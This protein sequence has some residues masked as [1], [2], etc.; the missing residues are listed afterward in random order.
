METYLQFNL[1][2][3]SGKNTKIRKKVENF[4]VTP[5]KDD[6]IPLYKGMT[7]KVMYRLLNP[8]SDQL[9][10]ICGSKK[11]RRDGAEHLDDLR[12][13]GWEIL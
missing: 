13:N 7:L 6:S 2:L 12:G 9:L 5:Q 11:A 8:G 10:V 1:K 3:Q 4:A